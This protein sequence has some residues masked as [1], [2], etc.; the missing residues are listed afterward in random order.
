MVDYEY[1]DY[2]EVINDALRTM[3]ELLDKME[4]SEGNTHEDLCNC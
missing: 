4:E 3:N 1:D 2:R